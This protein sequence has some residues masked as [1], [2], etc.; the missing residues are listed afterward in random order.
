MTVS[1]RALVIAIVLVAVFAGAIAYWTDRSTSTPPYSGYVEAEYVLV[2]SA[3][4][5]TL[6]TV[7]V[8]R[9][10]RVA[11]GARLF[12]MD[13]GAERA[14]RDEAAGRLRQAE[15]QYADLLT[16]RRPAEIDAIEAQRSQ[17]EAALQQ[18]E[19]EFQRQTTLRKT[20]ASSAQQLEIARK[21]R[22]QD[23]ARIN[24]LTAQLRV[25]RLPGRDEQ[26][27]AAEAA[28]TAAK[29][30]LAQ[31]EWRL[32]QKS[33]AAPAAA[34]VVDTLYRPGEMVG[35][36]APVVQLLPAENIKIRFFVPE[37]AVAGLAIGERVRITCDG[38][39]RP[40]DAAVS[41]ISPQAEFTPPVIYSRDERARLVFMVE[42]RPTA[43]A[44]ILRVGQPVDVEEV[45]P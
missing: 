4:G 24:E 38:C 19:S 5:G 35:A 34:T 2:G 30:T 42:A 31:A 29:G 3:V 23:R 6:V 1:R 9:G 15:A 32:A 14:A 18:S 26:I 28:V 39:A 10:D 22:D 25:A 27:K 16:G 33:G 36:G 41:F 7:D 40:V 12:T 43:N 45:G 21:Q 17:A 13:D 11:A 37:T 44:E 20:G 8:R